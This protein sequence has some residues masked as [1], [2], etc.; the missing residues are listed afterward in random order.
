MPNDWTARVWREYRAGTLTR[1]FR[2]ALLT[3]RT[4][5]GHGGL[6]CPAH[7]TLAERAR[8]SV[9]SVQR[10]LLQAQRLGLLAWAERRV[11]A[12]WRWLRT[13][14]SYWL[15]V[16]EAPVEPSMRPTWWRRRTTGQDGGVGE[17]EKKEAYEGRRA[18]LA[19]MIREAAGSPDLLAMRRAAVEALLGKGVRCS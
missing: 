7:E 16:P 5:R 15:T 18:A 12:G 9:S 4:Y 2:D 14:N 11:R 17:S 1:T 3:L 19:R 10:A 8:C 13:S 6:I